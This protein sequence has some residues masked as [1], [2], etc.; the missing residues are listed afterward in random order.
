VFSI[1]FSAIGAD[2]F[3][4]LLCFC[5]NVLL[6]MYFPLWLPFSR[7]ILKTRPPLEKRRS[8]IQ[9]K[10]VSYATTAPSLKEVFIVVVVVVYS[11]KFILMF[12]S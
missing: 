6:S 8:V 7:V 9:I 11:L 12:L 3:P 1:A 4:L 2:L 10:R 5:H